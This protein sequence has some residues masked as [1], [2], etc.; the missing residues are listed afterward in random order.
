[1]SYYPI[2]TAELR[3]TDAAF[4][5]PARHRD[6]HMA[7]LG[8]SGTGKSTLLFNLIALDIRRGHG[9]TVIDPHG[10]LIEELLHVIPRARINDVIYFDPLHPTHNIGINFLEPVADNRHKSRVASSLIS[11][12][13]NLWKE[14]WGRR[15]EYL[16][17]NATYA[18]LAQPEPQ[19]LIGL[20]LFLTNA[21]YRRYIFAHARHDPAIRSFYHTYEREWTDRQRQEATSAPLNKVNKFVLNPL[22]RATFGQ[23]LSSFQFRWLMDHRKILLC[24]LPAGE[25]GEDV[26]A[27]IGSSVI[28]SLFLAALTRRNIPKHKRIPHHLYA[29]EVQTFLYGTSLPSLLGQ[30]RK[31]KLAVC[32]ASQ[33]LSQLPPDCPDAIFGNCGTIASFRVSGADAERLQTEFATTKSPRTFQTVPDYRLYIKTLSTDPHG[34]AAPREPERITAYPSL[35]DDLRT[36][37][38]VMMSEPDRVVKE[39]VG[40]FSRPREKVEAQIHDLLNTFISDDEDDREE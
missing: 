23:P 10:D 27:I 32:I 19:T 12:F 2:G 9:V 16:I 3:N 24:H 20:Q 39:S 17:E 30:S 29:D 26:S 31:Y 33:T 18:L 40:R 15:T 11:I 34:V 35:K 6:R 13:T 37:A 25:M 38:Q 36:H 8:K 5:I 28:T 1:M 7:I 22:L 4:E 21:A 14:N